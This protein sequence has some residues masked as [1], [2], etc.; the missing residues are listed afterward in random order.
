MVF[1]DD[2]QNLAKKCDELGGS[3]QRNWLLQIA[4]GAVGLLYLIESRLAVSLADR[5][6]IDAEF[7]QFGLPIVCL[8]LQSPHLHCLLLIRALRLL[9]RDVPSDPSR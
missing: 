5:F 9:A 7:I 6:N 3:L 1:S 8:L 4:V 2:V